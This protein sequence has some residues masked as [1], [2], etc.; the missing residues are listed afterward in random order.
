MSQIFFQETIYRS[1]NWGTQPKLLTVFLGLYEVEPFLDRVRDSISVQNWTNDVQL[2]VVDNASTFNAFDELCPLVSRLPCEV[3]WLRN[4]A[5]YQ[6]LGS[7]YASAQHIGTPWLTFMHQDDSYFS[8]FVSAIIREIKKVGESL[9]TMSI[10][11]DYM[12]VREGGTPSHS[13]NPTWFAQ[14]GPPHKVFLQNIANHALPWP[15]TAFRTEYLF[16]KRVPFHS[17]AFPDTEIA[18]LQASSGKFTYVSEVVMAYHEEIS[19]GSRSLVVAEQESLRFTSLLRVLSSIEFRDLLLTLPHN[20]RA[21]W[22]SEVLDASS[23]YFSSNSLR[24]ILRLSVLEQ[25][26]SNSAYEDKELNFLLA[27]EL[28]VLGA[29]SA[30]EIVLGLHGGFHTESSRG[31]RGSLGRSDV[32]LRSF[33]RGLFARVWRA[34]PRWLARA[35]LRLLP[36]TLTPHPWKYYK[37]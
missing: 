33:V 3:L 17:S 4:K 10:S 6:A 18:L 28:T 7:L 1:P 24:S 8:N 32:K 5:N 27:N 12:S 20:E 25:L 19:S 37:R 14:S 36:K 30:A 15:S 2:I 26:V 35:T 22:L 29:T 9:E 11:F 16:S 13:A 31:D 23:A 34:L 21:P